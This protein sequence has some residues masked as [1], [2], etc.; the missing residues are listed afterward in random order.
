MM[1]HTDYWTNIRKR[2]KSG[3][4]EKQG[5]HHLKSLEDD[6]K[7]VRERKMRCGVHVMSKTEFRRK[8]MRD[9]AMR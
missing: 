5:Y 3:A 7:R 8:W 2:R 6:I 4:L 1:Q 9:H